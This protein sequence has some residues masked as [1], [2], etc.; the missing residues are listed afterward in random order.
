[1]KT[2]V[3]AMAVALLASCGNSQDGGVECMTNP[4]CDPGL[5]CIAT[6]AVGSSGV[7]APTGKK[8]CTKHCETDAEC[9]RSS[10]TCLTQCDGQKICG[11]VTR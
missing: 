10:P 2:F 9:V 8:V 1:M 3:L 7:C 6:V 4:D 11:S 5:S